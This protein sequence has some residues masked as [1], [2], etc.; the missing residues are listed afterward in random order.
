MLHDDLPTKGYT[1]ARPSPYLIQRQQCEPR[2][3]HL[4][5][6]W[7]FCVQP[8]DLGIVSHRSP[9]DNLHEAEFSR[10]NKLWL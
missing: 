7:V 3:L 2:L 6:D 1:S 5:W 9:R 4:Q 8:L 10:A